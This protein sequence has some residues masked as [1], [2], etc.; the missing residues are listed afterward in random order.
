MI[1][2]ADT[3]SV[4]YE[5][6]ICEYPELCSMLGFSYDC[7]EKGFALINAD[8]NTVFSPEGD[9]GILLFS[10]DTEKLPDVYAKGAKAV[11]TGPE[12]VRSLVLN[13]PIWERGIFRQMRG[14]AETVLRLLGMPDTLKGFSYVAFAAAYQSFLP[15]ATFKYDVLPLMSKTFCRSEASFE[16][17][18]RYAVEYAWS[19]G[20]INMQEKLFGYS[21]SAKSGKPST[22][23]VTSMLAQI[24]H[25]EREAEYAQAFDT[26]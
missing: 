26:V 20:D 21:V 17:A 22:R 6:L 12:A 9:F 5:Q 1:Y 4:L 7:G 2:I 3:D 15:A 24:L 25:E 19:N 16:R 23:E 10:C 11:C 18:M 14:S 13:I 8:C